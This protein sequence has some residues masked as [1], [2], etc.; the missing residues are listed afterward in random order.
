MYKK[1]TYSIGS[2][3]KCIK[4]YYVLFEKNSIISKI[5]TSTIESSRL[6]T[7]VAIYRFLII[8]LFYK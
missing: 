7:K 5:I 3:K 2:F 4:K 8:A 1:L 6:I